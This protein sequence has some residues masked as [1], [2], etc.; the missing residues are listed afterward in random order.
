MAH[1]KCS[2]EFVRITVQNTPVWGLAECLPG[3]NRVYG[4]YPIYCTDADLIVHEFGTGTATIPA[5]LTAEEE[6]SLVDA[7]ATDTP[8]VAW[9]ALATWRLTQ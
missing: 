5:G 7:E 3:T 6:A 9:A 2:Q 1:L 8:D 4:F